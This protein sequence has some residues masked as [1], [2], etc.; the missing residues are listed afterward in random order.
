MLKLMSNTKAN[1]A[2]L[3]LKLNLIAGIARIARSARSA[4][5]ALKVFVT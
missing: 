5:S 2:D 4:R 1:V 3:M